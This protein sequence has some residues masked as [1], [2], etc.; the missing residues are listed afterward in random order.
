MGLLD[1]VRHK[2][3]HSS[4]GAPQIGSFFK[5]LLAFSGPGYLIA[6]GYMDPGN[7]A[8]DIAGGAAFGYLLLSVVVI[9]SVMAIMLQTLSLRL[10]IVTETDLAARC[11]MQYPPW[12]SFGLWVLAEIGIIACDLAELLGTAIA[13]HLLFSL[14]ILIAMALT[15]A[16]ILILMSVQQWRLRAVE[17]MVVALILLIIGC[18]TYEMIVSAPEMARIV[19]GIIPDRRILSDESALYLAIGIIGATIMPHN[20]YLHSALIQTRP[21][22]RTELGKR[23]AIR[24]STIDAVIALTIACFLNGA[25]LILAASNFHPAGFRAVGDLED[26]YGILTPLLG[27]S[28][29]LCFALAL[30]AA[31]QN[32]TLTGTMAGEIVMNGFITLRVSPRLRRAVTRLLALLPS[33]AIVG[34][35]G[36]SKANTLLIVSQVILSLQLPFAAVP[37]IHFAGDRRLMGSFTPHPVFIALCWLITGTIIGLNGLLLINLTGF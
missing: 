20:L 21:Y 12:V 15:S 7:W 13:L 26:A 23:E 17:A 32:A 14:P 11:R 37:L 9:S 31:G 18:F 6:V 3:R 5:K 1:S 2:Q 36:E 22:P 35:F 24:F 34:Y 30:L 19:D 28:A 10:G 16:D 33:L 29:A 8:T 25:I 27:S 4:G